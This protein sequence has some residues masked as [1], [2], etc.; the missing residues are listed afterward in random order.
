M[1]Y[2]TSIDLAYVLPTK[3]CNVYG[4]LEQTFNPS[5]TCN[6][7]HVWNNECPDCHTFYNFKYMPNADN[8]R[9]YDCRDKNA[10]I[11]IR[12]CKYIFGY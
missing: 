8:T 5:G 6:S 12:I 11:I 1:S 4:C 2:S 3:K 7:F 10:N 9:C